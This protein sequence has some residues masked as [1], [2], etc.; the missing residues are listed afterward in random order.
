MSNDFADVC[1]IDL[2]LTYSI[3]DA[4]GESLVFRVDKDDDN[5][6]LFHVEIGGEEVDFY[7]KDVYKLAEWLTKSLEAIGIAHSEKKK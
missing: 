7:K 2:D 5:G 3:A 1:N 4:D 6:L